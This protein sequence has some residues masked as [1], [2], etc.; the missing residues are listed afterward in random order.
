[1]SKRVFVVDDPTVA[2]EVETLLRSRGLNRTSQ[3]NADLPSMN[4]VAQRG[5][6]VMDD[7]MIEEVDFPFF[8]RVGNPRSV[9]PS[10]FPWRDGDVTPKS[11]YRSMGPRVRG[12]ERIPQMKRPSM[13]EFIKK[14]F[15][16]AMSK[17]SRHPF[18]SSCGTFNPE[19]HPTSRLFV[20]G[21]C[22][23]FIPADARDLAM[24]RQLYTH[25]GCGG[26]E[27]VSQ[28]PMGGCVGTTYM[29]GC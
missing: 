2:A 19:P 15:N 11:E 5:M 16:N 22:G 20:N 25:S 9:S 3:R 7:D 12:I 6:D 1:M 29:S 27:P 17:P 18:E 8:K 21:A 10:P 28:R 24:G 26:F 13:D 14:T 4:E 23:G